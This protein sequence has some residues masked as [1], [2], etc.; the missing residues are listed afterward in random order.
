MSCPV[1]AIFF[2]AELGPLEN[3]PPKMATKNREG[4]GKGAYSILLDLLINSNNAQ[5]H[6]LLGDE[7]SQCLKHSKWR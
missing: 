3:P 6:L 2:S 4:K 7:S 1:D 5:V